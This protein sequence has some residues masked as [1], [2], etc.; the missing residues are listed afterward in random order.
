MDY[1]QRYREL[2]AAGRDRDLALAVLRREGARFIQCMKA[3]YEV[4]GLSLGECKAVVHQSPAW[5][6]EAEAREAFW[7]EVIW[8]LEE[9]AGA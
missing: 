8:L 3:V 1:T 4:D 2:R 6:D 9:E 7:D 5:S